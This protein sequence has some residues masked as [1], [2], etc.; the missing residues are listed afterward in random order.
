[1]NEEV[2]T[3]D[4]IEVS[5][6][7]VFDTPEGGDETTT[8]QQEQNVETSEESTDSIETSDT[9]S[10]VVDQTEEV[11]EPVY[12]FTDD[13]G[14]GFTMDEINAWR[15]DSNN[16]ENW[17]KSNTQSAQELASNEKAI[18]PF[19]EFAEKVRGDDEKLIPVLEYVKDEYGEEVEQLF[20]DSIAIDKEKVKNPFQDEFDKVVA[21][22]DE[23]EARVKFDGLVTDFSKSSGLKGKKLDDIVEWTT[24]HFE[25]TGRLLSFDEAHKILQ[26]DKMAED[27]KMKRP[28]PP[29]K[30]KKSQGA[31]GITTKQ[32][33]SKSGNYDEIDVSGFNLFG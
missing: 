9:D 16:K 29:T 2:K 17:Q 21:E 3:Y 24:S 31:K 15:D 13:D 8:D 30:V 23:L 14:N 1:M 25:D 7:E 28:S 20:K 22:K 12:V 11:E 5:E 6:S 26:A 33:P 27:S 18:Q 10:E 19:L 32:S 4:D